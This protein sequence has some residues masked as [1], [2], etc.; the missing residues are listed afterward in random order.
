[1]ASILFE[2]NAY[3]SAP[4]ET[5]L[6]LLQRH[7]HDIPSSCR[8]GVCQSCLLRATDGT[9]PD[10][11]RSGVKETLR[12]RGYFLACRCEPDGDLTVELPAEGVARHATTIT[13]LTRLTDNVIELRVAQPEGFE[14]RAGQF[15]TLIS[16]DNVG[17]SY[18]IA[19]VPGLDD[20][21]AFQIALIPGGAMSAWL[22]E[23][24]APGVAVEVQGPNGDCFYVG[25]G[26]AEQPLLLAGTGTGLAPLYGIARDA[27]HQGHEGPVH[28]FHG[29]LTADGL[30][31]DETLEQL[32]AEHPTL[33]YYPCALRGPVDDRVHEGKLDEYLFDVLPDLKGFRAYLCGAP[34]FVT[35]MQRKVFMG[36]VSMQAIYADKFLPAQPVPGS[37]N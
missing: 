36:G 31:L 8:S 17:R 3:A 7:G 28:L 2:G 6:D 29:S 35:M 14:Y 5:V 30:Y 10:A 32:A 34:E 25:A 1:M 21:L 23:H 22:A 11:A 20:D 26:A 4:G 13:A 16:P 15:A 18:S 19:S 27:L 12:E 24:A 37:G 9:P 33:K